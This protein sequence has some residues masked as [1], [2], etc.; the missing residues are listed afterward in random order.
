[1]LSHEDNDFVSRVGPGTPMGTLMREYWIPAMLASELPH[2][3]SDPV[4][5]LCLLGEKLIAFRDSS[6]QIGLINNLCPHRGASLFFGRNEEDGLRC[7]YHGWKFDRLGNCVDMPNEPAES[8]FKARISATAY[9]CIERGGIV[10][11]YLGPRETPPPLP[12]FEANQLPED[13]QLVS[14]TMRNCN[15][16]QALEGDLDTSHLG[17]LHSGG[18]Q[19]GDRR[20][21]GSFGYYTVA[22]R[23]PRYMAI[24]TDYGAMYGAYRPAEPGYLYWRVAQFLFPFYTQ[25]PTG[26]LGHQVLSRAWVP[27]DDYHVMFFFY[28]G[29]RGTVCAAST[30]AQ[31][32][33]ARGLAMREDSTGSWYGR[34]RLV[35]DAEQQRLL[36][37]PRSATR[38]MRSYMGIEGI[39]VQDGA[40]TESMGSLLNS[41][42]MST[43]A[44]RT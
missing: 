31:A 22:D 43:S 18:D 19:A 6:G 28:M 11:A 15:W 25:I 23:S 37:R 8:N 26:I 9:P 13:E 36:D 34:H 7:V 12:D 39:P 40:V 41:V 10:W 44:A 4:R 20:A 33:A 3:D 32:P 30:D 42:P 38:R 5:A 14:A 35:Q 16:L 24:D 2:P 27:M 1:M 21:P 29:T 17:F